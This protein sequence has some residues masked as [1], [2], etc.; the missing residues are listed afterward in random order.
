MTE[1]ADLDVL[2]VDCQTTGATPALGAVLHIGWGVLRQSQPGLEQPQAH[3]VALPQGHVVSRQVRRLTGF[4]ERQ[5]TG[6]LEPGVVWERL[7]ASMQGEV[8]PTAIHFAR[9]EFNQSVAASK[10]RRWRLAAGRRASP[11]RPI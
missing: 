7:R 4:D 3:W 8:M 11:L 10:S 9:F 1:L 6:V 2:V 5:L